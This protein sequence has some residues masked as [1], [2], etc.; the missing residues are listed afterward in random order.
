MQKKLK[1]G[2]FHE[3]QVDD[4]AATRRA[5]MLPMGQRLSALPVIRGIARLPGVATKA[6]CRTCTVRKWRQVVLLP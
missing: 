1:E 6:G 2:P 5:R 3:V 4:L